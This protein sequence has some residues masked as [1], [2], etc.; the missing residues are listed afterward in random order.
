LLLLCHLSKIC[1]NYQLPSCLPTCYFILYPNHNHYSCLQ[2]SGVHNAASF[3]FGNSYTNKLMGS[4]SKILGQTIFLENNKISNYDQRNVSIVQCF[5]IVSDKNEMI[6][7][8]SKNACC[9]QWETNSWLIIFQS[10]KQTNKQTNKQRLKNQRAKMIR[11]FIK[12]NWI[13]KISDLTIW[14]QTIVGKD[15]LFEVTMNWRCFED[16]DLP[17]GNDLHIFGEKIITF[18]LKKRRL[19]LHKQWW[20]QKM[21]NYDFC[22]N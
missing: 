6:N 11:Y 1:F 8:N 21:K 14:T 17:N 4:H 3:L 10:T 2:L 15:E 18:F 19:H 7:F 20:S 12:V 22:W 16:S 13:R 5:L 9:D